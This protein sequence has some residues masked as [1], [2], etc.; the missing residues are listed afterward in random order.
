MTSPVTGIPEFRWREFTIPGSTPPVSLARLYLEDGGGVTLLVR[1]PPGW[2]RPGTGHYDAIEEV[3]FLEGGFQMSG[4]TYGPDSYGW[5][6]AG[7]LR[8]DSAS[9]D[10]ALALAWF[11]GVNNWYPGSSAEAEQTQ[12]ATIVAH[13]PSA[14]L[15]GSPLG[16][17]S[18]RLLHPS[19]ERPT[20]I[21]DQVP[22]GDVSDRVV[23]L[24]SL[25]SRR[26]ARVVPGD[27]LPVLDGPA[28][29]RRDQQAP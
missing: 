12:P 29:C 4:A 1:F 13:W 19:A 24:F 2:S 17:G 18:A 15:L 22:A 11:S 6:P 16:Q 20:W 5:F 25:S 3:L 26:W 21:V 7:Y 27:E 8:V 9:P 23:E 10:G 14:P 28:F